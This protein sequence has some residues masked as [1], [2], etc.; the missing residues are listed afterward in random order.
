[1]WVNGGFLQKAVSIVDGS[2][3]STIGLAMSVPVYLVEEISHNEYIRC[4]L[5][6]KYAKDR[7]AAHSAITG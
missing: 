4:F 3:S 6:W 2:R 1:M 5:S 7:A